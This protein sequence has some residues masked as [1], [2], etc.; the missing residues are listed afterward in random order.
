MQKPGGQL[1]TP[2][3]TPDAPPQQLQ[4]HPQ[5]QIQPPWVGAKG[6]YG[7]LQR[8]APV[9]QLGQQ[10]GQMNLQGGQRPVSSLQKRC[11]P[12]PNYRTWP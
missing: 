5:M 10:F 9:A 3:F 1:S 2:G 8:D 7:Q 6:E 12:F 4:P 11:S